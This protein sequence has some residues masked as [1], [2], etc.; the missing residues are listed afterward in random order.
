[1]TKL[2]TIITELVHHLPYSATGVAA[3][4]GILLA[5]EKMDWSYLP[6]NFFHIAHP[7]HIFLS[8]VVTTAIFWKYNHTWFKTVLVGLLGTIPICT[9]SDIGMPYLGGWWLKT[10]IVFHLCVLEEPWLVF[11]AAAAGIAVG[12]FLLDWV[13]NGTEITHLAHVLVSSLASLLYLVTFDPSLWQNS[14]WLVFSIT[15]LAV[16]IPCCLSD[17]VFP[18]LFTDNPHAGCHHHHH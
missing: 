10:P 5:V 7:L 3:S 2:K 6:T 12:M 8:A 11:P 1:M 17:I 16:W 15:V 13:E 14:L 18:L 9:I 4:L